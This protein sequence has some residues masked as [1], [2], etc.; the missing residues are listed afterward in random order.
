MHPV[1]ASL[2]SSPGYSGFAA[3]GLGRKAVLP[4][5]QCLLSRTGLT[6]CTSRRGG[7]ALSAWIS[8]SRQHCPTNDPSLWQWHI[9]SKA[10]AENKTKHGWTE[11]R[12]L[13]ARV[14]QQCYCKAVKLCT[15]SFTGA[16]ALTP[17]VIKLCYENNTLWS[18]RD[19][20]VLWHPGSREHLAASCVLAGPRGTWKE[21]L[22]QGVSGLTHSCL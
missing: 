9:R 21:P 5:R 4:C 14:A 6:A 11:C 17:A 13:R 19:S 7:S 18:S 8:K 15:V 10:A 2:C 16:F 12:D 3:D 1:D 22:L 20:P